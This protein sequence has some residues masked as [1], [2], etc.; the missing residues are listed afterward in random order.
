[1]LDD[2]DLG[3]DHYSKDGPPEKIGTTQLVPWFSILRTTFSV[4]METVN[5]VMDCSMTALLHELIR[6]LTQTSRDGL[7]VDMMD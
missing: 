4:P 7:R 6:L 1:M 2:V 3:G 5:L